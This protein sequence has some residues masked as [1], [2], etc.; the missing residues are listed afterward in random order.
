[1]LN[2]YTILRVTEHATSEEIKSAYRTLAKEYHPDLNPG[3][4]IAE[5][6]FKKVNEAYSVLSDPI[7]RNW[8]NILLKGNAVLENSDPRKYGTRRRYSGQ[9]TEANAEDQPSTPYWLKQLMLGLAMAWGLLIIFN[10]WFTTY[11]GNEFGKMVLAFLL[12]V[13][14]LY[15]FINNLYLKW[16]KKG[17][18][19]NPESRSLKYFLL[20][21]FLTIPAFFLV[22]F[23]R[24]SVHLKFYAQETDAR[25]IE[26]RIQDNNYWVNV[27][28]FDDENIP[29]SKDF[30]FKSEVELKRNSYKIQ[31]KYSS[32]EP[33][34]MQFHVKLEGKDS[35]YQEAIDKI[36]KG[37]NYYTDN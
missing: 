7:K 1:M 33:R 23:V 11:A 20:L 37:G 18:S 13:V 30:T 16:Q 17:V 8:Y 29:Y 31:I 28:Y 14:A 22:G 25:L 6:Y 2:Y 12:F 24:K 15:F 21:F 32:L 35:V 26:Y 5:E 4:T 9:N 19:F 10:N 34:I 27:V 3:N 36:N